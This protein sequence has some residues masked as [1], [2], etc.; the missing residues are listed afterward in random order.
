MTIAEIWRTLQDFPF[1]LGY[2]D[3]NR[4]I[5]VS[6]GFK[7]RLQRGQARNIEMTDCNS[8]RLRLLQDFM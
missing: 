5:L 3:N 4:N 8:L 1:A 2:T 7:D 6:R